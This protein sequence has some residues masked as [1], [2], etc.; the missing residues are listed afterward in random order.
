MQSQ[1]E[2]AE[3]SAQYSVV[4]KPPETVVGYKDELAQTLAQ[5]TRQRLRS[6]EEDQKREDLAARRQREVER[7]ELNRQRLELEAQ[8]A[9]MDKE[10]RKAM[11]RDLRAR[12]ATAFRA[13]SSHRRRL[14]SA[15]PPS[16]SSGEAHP[17]APSKAVG[18]EEAQPEIPLPKPHEAGP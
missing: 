1:L 7:T 10:M 13:R 11:Q 5:L 16:P 17:P 12:E 14:L 8:A 18:A 9:K 4:R 15:Q 3:R 2:W 6:K